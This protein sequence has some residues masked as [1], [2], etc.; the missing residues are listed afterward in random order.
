M[1]P[2]VATF[3]QELKSCL[4]NLSATLMEP[5]AKKDLAGIKVALEKVESPAVKLCRL[6]PFEIGVIEPVRRD[7]GDIP[8]Q[9]GRQGERFIQAMTW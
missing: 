4:N 7:S 5:V 6:C 3:K 1:S 9:R 2:G 8:C